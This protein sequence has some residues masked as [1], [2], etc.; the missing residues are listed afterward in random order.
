MLLELA[1]R[2]ASH[3]WVYDKIQRAAGV[4]RV[5]A[6]LAPL[7][8]SGSE[9]QLVL[10]IGGGTGTLK[11][12]CS[13]S[14]RY[15]CLDI[16][17]KKLQGFRGK[18]P[19][20]LGIW[21]DAANLPI[22]SGSV[23]TVICMFVAHH[24]DDELLPRVLSEVERTLRAGGRVILL[25]PVMDMRRIA[26]RILWKLDRGSFPRT[27]AILKSVLEQRFALVHWD[28]FAVWHGYILGVGRKRE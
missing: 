5:Y 22:S 28:Q 27:P 13:P 18:F 4:S 3:P 7:L 16:E 8:L 25:D 14:H 11:N 12:H 23:D 2:I 1:H 21:G 19:K 26:G 17:W 10:D 15:V 20:G 24:L 9:N 6:K